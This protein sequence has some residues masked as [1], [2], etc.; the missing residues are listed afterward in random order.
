MVLVVPEF[1]VVILYPYGSYGNAVEPVLSMSI[2]RFDGSECDAALYEK[3][4]N[5]IF[6]AAEICMIELL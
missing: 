5:A 1:D 6:D 3:R 4:M 2:E